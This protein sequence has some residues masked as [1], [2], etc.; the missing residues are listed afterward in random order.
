[1]L[2]AMAITARVMAPSPRWPRMALTKVRYRGLSKNTTRLY[3]LA[4]FANL[5]RCKQYLL[6]QGQCA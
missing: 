3:L 2:W 5:V 1:M 4:G 6:A